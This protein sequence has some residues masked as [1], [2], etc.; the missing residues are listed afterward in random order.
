[1]G[2]EEFRV[3][4]WEFLVRAC[5]P[6]A[7]HSGSFGNQAIVMREEVCLPDGQFA[8]VPYITGD[9]IRHGI[10]EA[11]ALALLDA[12]G[13]LD[14]P[15]LSESALRLLFAGGMITGKAA[16]SSIN[17]DTY[18]L[19]CELM[20][21]LKLLGGC[22]DNRMIPGTLTVSSG[23]LVCE[24]NMQL[25]REA[26][27]WVE[28]WMEKNGFT[29]STA[30]EYVTEET[31]VRMDPM[32]IPERR[33]LLSS[34]EQ[35][36]VNNRMALSERA[37]TEGDDASALAAKSTMMPRT[38][39]AIKRGS[40]FHFYVEAR[41]Y[42]ALDRDTFA[43]MVAS[44][45]SNMR[46]GGKRGTGHGLMTPLVA[47]DVEIVRPSHQSK[48]LALPGSAAEVGK[49]FREHVARRAVELRDM[50]SKVAA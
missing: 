38:C 44:F 11:S 23:K 24:E 28:E 10:R 26:H 20:P 33:N 29:A 32:L 37:H 41:T 30:A 8:E 27:P 48:S 31:R 49:L 42:S 22:A 35:V 14:N 25:F 21:S 4:R 17:L 13:M 2:G 19:M 36:A 16:Q 7:H 1:M 9:T 12:A 46:V 45:I 47:R 50:L 5:E 15:C 3:M 34:A 43:V 18:R 40:V 6:I 39:E